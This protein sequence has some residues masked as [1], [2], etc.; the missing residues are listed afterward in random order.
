MFTA[1]SRNS[2]VHPQFPALRFPRF[3]LPL[4]L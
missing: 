4:N 1:S 2:T 3:A